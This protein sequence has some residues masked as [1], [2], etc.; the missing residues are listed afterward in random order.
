MDSLPKFETSWHSLI[1]SFKLQWIIQLSRLP[2]SDCSYPLDIA[3]V[4]DASGSVGHRSFQLVKSF[5]KVFTHHFEVTNTT[6][7]SCLHY[8]HRV[9]IDFEFK[10][11]QY[12][13]HSSLDAKI[14]DM[15]YPS[16]AT[17]TNKALIEAKTFFFRLNGARNES[18]VRRVCIIVTDGKTHYGIESLIHPVYELKVP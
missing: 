16:G 8:D 17:L 12:H 9:Y 5:L 6:H 7:F 14:Q 11:T 13:N 3:L 4:I 1:C 15:S 10:D 18:D 2:F